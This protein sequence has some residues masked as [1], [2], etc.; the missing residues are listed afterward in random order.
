MNSQEI[1]EEALR[2]AGILTSPTP[3]TVPGF[4]PTY[5]AYTTLLNY[6]KQATALRRLI[7]HS[8]LAHFQAEMHNI[9]REQ[10]QKQA[11]LRAESLAAEKKRAQVELISEEDLELFQKFKEQQREDEAAKQR[12][13]ERK[14]AEELAAQ[15]E[16][17]QAALQ[18]FRV[19]LDDFTK[20]L[21]GQSDAQVI[22]L[23][24]QAKVSEGSIEWPHGFEKMWREKRYKEKIE[25]HN[26]TH[27]IQDY[28]W[29][30]HKNGREWDGWPMKDE[31]DTEVHQLLNEEWKR[32][33]NFC[34]R[35][36]ERVI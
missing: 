31:V 1:Y 25:W 35:Y 17:Q 9:R 12:K 26:Y 11:A 24:Q 7:P 5:T 20:M 15:K 21:Y 18:L 33:I 4:P 19:M 8:Q 13:E 27:S 32:W 10:E 29:H 14:R 3:L 2:R 28:G 6:P 16:E 34:I 23:G 22:R 36:A 30:P